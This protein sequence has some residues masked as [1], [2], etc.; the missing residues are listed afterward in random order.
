MSDFSNAREYTIK[1]MDLVES[2]S[3]NEVEL[4]RDLLNYMSE[5]DVKDFACSNEYIEDCEE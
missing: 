4:I 2:G 3:V 1:L 5:E